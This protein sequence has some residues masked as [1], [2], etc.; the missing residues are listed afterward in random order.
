LGGKEMTTDKLY[1]LMIV[2]YCSV[3]LCGFAGLLIGAWVDSFKVWIRLRKE[4]Q[5]DK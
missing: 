5:N 2:I 3:I 1:S 4:K